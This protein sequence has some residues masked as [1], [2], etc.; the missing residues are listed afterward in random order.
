MHKPLEFT[1]NFHPKRRNRLRILYSELREWNQARLNRKELIAALS[2]LDLRT[3]DDI[4]V[5]KFAL[6]AC[7]A[8]STYSPYSLVVEAL[9]G[10]QKN[11]DAM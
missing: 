5:N 6:W 2:A 8:S 3:L 1:A 10:G 4:G 7:Q 9:L 11:R